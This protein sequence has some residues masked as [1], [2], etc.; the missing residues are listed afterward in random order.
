MY[1]QQDRRDIGFCGVKRGV[2]FVTDWI[3][4]E[5]NLR[6]QLWPGALEW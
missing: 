3:Y 4:V 2:V 6:Q 1:E 5:Y